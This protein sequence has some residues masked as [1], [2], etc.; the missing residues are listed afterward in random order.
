MTFRGHEVFWKISKGLFWLN[1]LAYLFQKS[2]NVVRE[3]RIL[4]LFT[5]SSSFIVKR[6]EKKLYTW[7]IFKYLILNI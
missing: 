2:K 6:I 4:T 3:K 1:P 5:E 7:F